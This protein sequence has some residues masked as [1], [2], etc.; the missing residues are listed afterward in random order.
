MTNHFIIKCKECGDTIAQCRCPSPNKEVKYQV[1][2]K[3][4]NFLHTFKPSFLTMTKEQTKETRPMGS[5]VKEQLSVVIEMADRG[6][7]RLSADYLLE[8]FN[9]FAKPLLAQA[10]KEERERF[11][12]K[13]RKYNIMDL[14]FPEGIISSSPTLLV[15][16]LI[17]D[18]ID[19][20]LSELEA[21]DKVNLE[22]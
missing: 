12:G 10:R 1:C 13:L 4:S 2:K 18:A 14:P 11:D 8:L 19:Q 6:K 21:E 3:C 20:V 22:R 17:G 16:D 5:E 9:E 15:E 7:K